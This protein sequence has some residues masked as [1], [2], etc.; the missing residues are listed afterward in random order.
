[1][2]DQ[3]RFPTATTGRSIERA[4][5]SAK[6]FQLRG[7]GE[8]LYGASRLEVGVD[9]NGRFDLHALDDLIQY[10]VGGDVTSTRSNVSVDSANRTD[11]GVYATLETCWRGGLRWVPDSAAT[12]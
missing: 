6:D 11:S 9:L 5:V 2:T 7:F 10:D 3:D 1:M 12:T 8:H 4:D